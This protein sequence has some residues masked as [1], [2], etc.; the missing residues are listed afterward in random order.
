MFKHTKRIAHNKLFL[1]SFYKM[2]FVTNVNRIIVFGPHAM[3][4]LESFI[5]PTAWFEMALKKTEHVSCA[6]VR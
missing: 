4:T 5:R 3:W 6:S 2:R 1:F